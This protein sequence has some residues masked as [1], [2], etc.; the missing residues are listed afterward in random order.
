MF[1]CAKKSF[2]L[3][4]AIVAIIVLGVGIVG[5]YA[6]LNLGNRFTEKKIIY[7]QARHLGKMYLN[8]ILS[9][10][11]SDPQNPLS[12]GREESTSIR[13]SFDDVDDYDSLWEMPPRTSSGKVMN[14]IDTLPDFSRY[15]VK[16][17]VQQVLPENLDSVVDISSDTTDVKRIWIKIFVHSVPKEV[18]SSDTTTRK[19]ELDFFGFKFKK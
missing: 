14:G 18:A 10:S 3:T 16:I 9:K 12:F 15:E 5:F 11:F 2:T 8:E 1:C 17:F 13:D 4:E 7:A 19:Y 6:L